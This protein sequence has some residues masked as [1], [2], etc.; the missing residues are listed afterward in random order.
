MFL[1]IQPRPRETRVPSFYSNPTQCEALSLTERLNP[2]EDL[3][4]QQLEHAV[5][6]LI[7]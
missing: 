6:S 4:L 3:T 1:A 7:N 2:S 5:F